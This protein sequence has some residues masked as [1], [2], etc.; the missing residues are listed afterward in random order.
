M[1]TT[2]TITTLAIIGAGALAYN[3]IKHDGNA[4]YNKRQR[5][6]YI[7]ISEAYINTHTPEEVGKYI[8]RIINECDW[9]D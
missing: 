4:C 7:T 5:E 1:I 8:D 6:Y 3:I 2:I 9:E